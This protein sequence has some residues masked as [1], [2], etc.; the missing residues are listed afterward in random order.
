[1]SDRGIDSDFPVFG[2]MIEPLFHISCRWKSVHFSV[3]S[4][5]DILILVYQHLILL[6]LSQS[7]L[8]DVLLLHIL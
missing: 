6:S 5:P 2:L 7:A 1:M 3:S 8:V 4:V